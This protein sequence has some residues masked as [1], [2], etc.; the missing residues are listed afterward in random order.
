MKVEIE[1]TDK[2]I[3]DLLTTALEGGSN[4][5]YEIVKYQ[6]PPGFADDWTYRVDTD[7]R[8]IF[9]HIDY[10]MN[11]GGSITI[12]SM[13]EPERCAVTLTRAKLRRGMQALASSKE[14]AHHFFD[15]LKEDMDDTTADVFLQFCLYGDVIYS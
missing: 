11:A 6:R 13:E 5:W 1:I 3:G 7:R 15:V 12:K 9:N 10:P 4:Y 8:S 14:Y 2:Q